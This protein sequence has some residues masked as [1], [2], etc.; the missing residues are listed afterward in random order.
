[1]LLFNLLYRYG[2]VESLLKYYKTA[3]VQHRT[4][5]VNHVKTKYNVDVR[6]IC[7]TT[8]VVDETISYYQNSIRCVYS[9]SNIILSVITIKDAKYFN[10]LYNR[11]GRGVV[12]Y[13]FSTPKTIKDKT[14]TLVVGNDKLNLKDDN[15]VAVFQGKTCVVL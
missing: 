3:D 2:T 9:L 7:N 8:D 13:S 12:E 11:L 15:E 5:I 6:E 10:T 4:E 1:M 14:W